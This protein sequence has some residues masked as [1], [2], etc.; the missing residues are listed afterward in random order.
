MLCDHAF[1]VAGSVLAPLL[2][3]FSVVNSLLLQHILVFYSGFSCL[4]YYVFSQQ[5]L[6]KKGAPAAHSTRNALVF[7]LLRT[8]NMLFLIFL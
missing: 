8:Y 1:G 5:E 2:A 7:A 4:R 6:V 3:G